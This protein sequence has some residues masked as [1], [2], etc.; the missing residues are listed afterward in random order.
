MATLTKFYKQKAHISYKLA[1]GSKVPGASTIAKL[2]D[3]PGALIHWAWQC[4]VDGEDYKK[5]RDTAADI[6]TLAHFMIQCFL[7]GEEPDLAEF[8]YA[9]AAK[10]SIC[11]LKFLDFWEREGLEVVATEVPLVSEACGFGGTVDLIA[12]DK[13]SQVLTIDWKT[14]DAIWP[15]HGFQIAAYNLLWNENHPESESQT[16]LIARIGKKDSED[17]EIRR[18]NREINQRVFLAQLNLYYELR[19]ASSKDAVDK[20]PSK[21]RQYKAKNFK[22]N[23]FEVEVGQLP[24]GSEASTQKDAV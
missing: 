12:V 19:R 8:S 17:F 5:V 16:C 7:R 2:G 11:F 13:L 9:D 4:G 22:G 18:I 24:Q 10:A 15:S 20:R 23:A 21:A 1:D 6:G 14:S 3:D